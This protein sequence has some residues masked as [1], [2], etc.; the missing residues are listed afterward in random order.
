MPPPSSPRAGRVAGAARGTLRIAP[1]PPGCPVWRRSR[2]A[3]SPRRRTTRR[4]RAEIAAILRSEEHT[5]ELQSH[6]N[7]VC[8]LLLEKKKQNCR[9]VIRVAAAD[10]E[11]TTVRTPPTSRYCSRHQRVT[12]ILTIDPTSFAARWMPAMAAHELP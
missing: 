7:L 9:H 1:F 6:L 11:L 8:R 2:H 10:A 4:P 5:S 12:A 3:N